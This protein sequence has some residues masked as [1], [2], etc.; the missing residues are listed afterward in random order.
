M[1]S[2]PS[3]NEN[4]GDVMKHA[5][6]GITVTTMDD[7]Q[8]GAMKGAGV[9]LGLGA[10]AAIAS[11]AIPGFGLVLG[12][13]AL[14]TAIGGM[15]AATAAGAVAGGV[16]GYLMDQGVEPSLVETF[17]K[18]VDAGGTMVSVSFPSGNANAQEIVMV[19]EKY[20]GIVQSVAARNVASVELS[21]STTPSHSR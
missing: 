19:L 16:A 21:D 4:A 3:E 5:K 18:T 2:M 6:E 17:T 14:A 10:V 9:G 15:A 12:G 8:A 7:A 1:K 13:G 20:G 11:I